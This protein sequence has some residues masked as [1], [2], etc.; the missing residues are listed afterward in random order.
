M[1][2]VGSGPSA[3]YTSKYLMKQAPVAVDM[4]ERLPT[5]FGLVRSGVAPD[6]A[7]V[8][9]VVNDF[10]DVARLAPFRFFGNV[11]VG[12]DVSLS[13]LRRHY[14]A[15]VLCTGAQS[16]RTLGIPG[17]G[18]AGVVG[19]PAFVQWYNSHPD[20]ASLQPREPGETAVVIG[21]GNVAID[22]AR[23]LVRSP[24]EMHRTDIDPRAQTLIASWQQRGLRTV[25]V[26]GRRGFIQAAFTNKEL[27][28]LDNLE[29]VLAVVDPEELQLCR[30]P[31]SEEEL[32]KSRMKK[33]SLGILEKMA[34]NFSQL[35]STSKRVIRLHF[36]RSPSEILADEGGQGVAGIRL[37]RTELQGSAGSQ[38]AALASSGDRVDLPCELVVRSVGFDLQ[39]FEGLPMDDR[40]SVPHLQGRVEDPEGGLYV[41]GWL[42]RGP[43]GIIA[44]NIADAQETAGR[45]L[46]DFK[47]RAP[48]GDPAAVEAILAG[49]GSQVVSFADWEKIEAHEA[50]Q[51]AQAGKVALKVTSVDEML[52]LAAGP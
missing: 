2:V 18:L 43:T 50:R 30:N 23:V 22:V 39:P 14:D 15:V 46:A 4:F 51:G 5:P 17:E 1:A 32:A 26:V 27:R 29:D 41:S 12:A 16:E 31:A 25:H 11:N 24:E 19:A 48:A 20:Y 7:E 36:L 38:R 49:S 34:D 21:Q 40:G 47:E 13:D 28:E 8:K 10:A 6:H 52:R 35:T 44:S 37:D 45:I 9:N 3:F 33:R 42:K